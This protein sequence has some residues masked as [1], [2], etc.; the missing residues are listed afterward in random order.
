M[1]QQQSPYETKGFWPRFR[2]LAAELYEFTAPK[3]DRVVRMRIMAAFACLLAAKLSNLVTPLLYGASVDIVN[4]DDGFSITLLWFVLGA[5]ALARIGQQVFAETKQYLFARVAQR[6]VRG[7]AMQAFRHLHK[8]SLKFHLDRQTGGMTR[9]VERGAKGVEFLLTMATFEILPLLI[10]VIFVSAILWYLFGAPY[11]I[12][13]F[14]T[15]VLYSYFTMRV[16][17]WRMRFRRQMNQADET[18]ATQAV[19]SLLNY[20][21]VKYFN[22]EENEAQRYDKAMRSYEDAAV[23]SRTS[24]AAVNVGQGAIISL[25]LVLVMGFAGWDIQQGNMSVGDFVA[26]NTFLL[27][28]YLPLNFLGYVYRE[29]RQSIIDLERMMNLIEEEP[30]I[31]DVPDAPALQLSHGEIAFQDVHFAYRDRPILKGVS[32]TVPAGKRVAI[33][34]PSGAGK[35]TLSRLLF[36]FYDPQQGSILIDGQDVRSVRQDSVRAAIGVVPQDTVMFNASIG[37]NIGYGH[38]GADQTAIENASKLAAIDGFINQLPDKYDSLVGERGLKL[39]G[40]EKQRV[41]IARAILKQPTIFLFDEATSALDSRTEK[42]IQ[43]SL[44]DVS[45]SQTTLVIAHRLSTIVD[46]DQILVMND[47]VIAERGT[48]RE[49][50]AQNGLYAVMWARQSDGF[51][52]KDDPELTESANIA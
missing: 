24:L 2:A 19:D 13:T 46:A 49:L 28:L 7:A 26:V 14:V 35:S 16:T 37:Y 17:E 12:I 34:G 40:G 51:L 15:V 36:R 47:G 11:A 1:N 6:A 38:F 4:G 18:A 21:T 29:V 3:G 9:A 32:F 43:K 30:D 41:A 31:K 50:L 5:Y 44:N 20:E 42:E 33:V 23:L 39:S 8:L 52:D 25:G 48:H 45:K 10:E 27:Q 22:N